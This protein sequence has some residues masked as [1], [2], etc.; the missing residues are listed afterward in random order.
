MLGISVVDALHEGRAEASEE[1]PGD[2]D[3]RAR[4]GIAVRDAGNSVDQK[5]QVVPHRLQRR[6]QRHVFVPRIP[7][8]VPALRLYRR[9]WGLLVTG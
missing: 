2:N 6:R 3:L 1:I 4:G 7:Q 5:L 9:Y 8:K